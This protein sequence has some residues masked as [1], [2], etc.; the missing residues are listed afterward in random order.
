MQINDEQYSKIIRALDRL[1][2]EHREL[3]IMLYNLK[4]HVQEIVKSHQPENV[5]L[6]DLSIE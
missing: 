3:R 2:I 4:Y 5:Q 6:C 1:D